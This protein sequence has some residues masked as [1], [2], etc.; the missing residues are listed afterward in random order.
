MP[1]FDRPIG[2]AADV[3]ELEYLSALHQTDMKGI[4]PDASIQAI[5]VV[6]FLS[7]RYGIRVTVAEVRKTILSGLGGGEGD[8]EVIDLAEVVAILIIPEL[9]K[10]A[11]QVE[12]GPLRR[13]EREEF[14]SDWEYRDYMER[15]EIADARMPDPDMLRLVLQNILQ[16]VTGSTEPRPLDRELIRDIFAAYGEHELVENVEIIDEMIAAAASPPDEGGKNDGTTG[17]PAQMFDLAAFARAL[18]YDVQLYDCDVE[19]RLST[20]YYDVMGT[21]HSTKVENKSCCG[22]CLS[23]C[24]K[25]DARGS[26]STAGRDSAPDDRG[27]TIHVVSDD[28]CFWEGRAGSTSVY[29]DG[30]PDSLPAS[31]LT[32]PPTVPE[33]STE[34]D[35]ERAVSSN[36]AAGQGDVK[37]VERTFTF[38]AIDYIA[39]TYRNKIFVVLLWVCGLAT[40]FAYLYEF[41][42]EFGDLNCDSVTEAAKHFGCQIANGIIHWFMIMLEL[43]IMGTIFIC[44]SSLGNSIYHVSIIAS[45]FGIGAV[46]TFIIVPFAMEFETFFFST[47]K[48]VDQLGMRMIYWISFLLGCTILVMQT[49]SLLRSIAPSKVFTRHPKIARRFAPPI[50]V[51]ESKMK[52]AAAFKLKRLLENAAGIHQ[53]SDADNSRHINQ[54]SAIQ[55]AYGKALLQY[56]QDA[57]P[58]CQYEEVGGMLW[59]IRNWRSGNLHNEEGIFLSSQILAGNVAQII[60]CLFVLVLA[61]DMYYTSIQNEDATDDQIVG[62]FAPETWMVL[63]AVTIGLGYGFI[64]AVHIT[65]A[66]LPSTVSTTLQFRCGVIPSL[67]NPC[68]FQIFRF[69]QDT[70]SLLFGGIFWGAFYSALSV[71][72]LIGSIVFLSVWQLTASFMW[73]LYARIL[74]L[75]ISVSLKLLLLLFLR[76]AYYSAFYRKKPAEANL[77]MVILESWGIA[78][79]TGFMLG[80]SLMLILSTTLNI[81]RIDRPFLAPGANRVGKRNGPGLHLDFY[82][83][84]FRKAILCVEA[85]RHP[86]VERL[87][88]MYMMK[89]RFGERF[90]RTSGSIWRLLFVFALMPWLR[91]YRIFARPELEDENDDFKDAKWKEGRKLPPP[92]QRYSVS[93]NSSVAPQLGI[94]QDDASAAAPTETT[95]VDDADDICAV[96]SE[97][98]ALKAEIDRLKAEL[99]RVDKRKK[100]DHDKEGPE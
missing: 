84:C 91:R 56:Q 9:L 95:E 7:S 4:R 67:K 34:N 19:T 86:Y 82:P 13:K 60:V 29:R 92:K 21:N 70:I 93:V 99:A 26:V 77:V 61:I 98:V 65:A 58:N 63:A 62:D 25:E 81:G 53:R 1:V 30:K 96:K 27:G 16:D 49:V 44:L 23:R 17:T 10:L 69:G 68:E 40:Y 33:Q 85:H 35:E 90:A 22:K 100:A 64:S 2:A 55:T 15:F 76:S 71:A 43:S 89:L 80:R 32:D 88:C 57:T 50:A 97:N 51:A 79:T 46:A 48:Q 28:D 66:Y 75:L 5:D 73:G 3:S 38:A 47:I 42:S 6:N 59:F 45:L 39:G 24:G 37:E 94:M 14:Q 87:G 18:T 83:V 78:L 11:R 74:G 41:N 12:Y 52:Q 31:M 20:H 72:V 54:R 8:D 36:G